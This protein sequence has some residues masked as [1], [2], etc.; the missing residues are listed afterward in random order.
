MANYSSSNTLLIQIVTLFCLLL[1][2]T[3]CVV[4]KYPAV[5][6]FGDSNSDTG[7]LVAARGDTLDPPNGQNYFKA[8]SGR[9]CDGRLIIDFLSNALILS[10]LIMYTKNYAFS[11]A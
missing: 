5:F 7:D 1:S 11:N 3:N 4:S 8:P 2:A 9:F 10:P 6:N